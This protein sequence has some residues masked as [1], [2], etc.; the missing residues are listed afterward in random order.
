MYQTAFYYLTTTLAM[1]MTM[2]ALDVYW[3][4]LGQALT[5]YSETRTRR[6]RIVE[7]RFYL[8]ILRIDAHP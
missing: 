2:K 5:T 6:T 4:L 1:T 3:Q 8:R 7:Q